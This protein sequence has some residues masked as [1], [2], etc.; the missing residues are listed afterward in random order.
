MK[1]ILLVGLGGFLGSIMRFQL[2]G[3][4]LHLT[5]NQ[6]FPTSTFVVNIVGC[7]MIGVLTGLAERHHIFS[8]ETRIFLIT[9][10]LGG[11]TT[12]SAFGYETVVL[13][14]SKEF[15]VAFLNMSLSVVLGILSVWIGMKLT[16][17]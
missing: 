8:Q 6:R 2:G 13:L 9:G 11:F 14:R 17:F 1:H 16:K 4:I 3:W 10:F 12:F 7:L 15:F 5:A